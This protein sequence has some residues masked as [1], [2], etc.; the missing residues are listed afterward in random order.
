MSFGPS[1]WLILWGILDLDLSALICIT[2]APQPVFIMGLL[3]K[4][5]GK[6]E[7]LPDPLIYAIIAVGA[8]GAVLSTIH[9]VS[10]WRPRKRKG[11]KLKG[12]EGKKIEDCMSP[13]G[14][15]L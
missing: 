7:T 10:T 12:A 14:K 13:K 9:H 3:S 4:L 2:Y 1:Q 6:L 15:E 8:T 11:V 5:I